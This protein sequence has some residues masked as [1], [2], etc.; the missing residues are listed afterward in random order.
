MT[1][2]ALTGIAE[3]AEAR[4]PLLACVLVHRTGRLLPGEPIVLVLTASPHREAALEST[5]FLIDWLKTKAPFWKHEQYA[6]GPSAW[7][8]A[9][10]EDEAATARW[11]PR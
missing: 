1:E 2:R 11:S 9:R 3:Q 4:W 10:E 7:V 5:A 8:A 6:V